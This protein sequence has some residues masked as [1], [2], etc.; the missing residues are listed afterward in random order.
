MVLEYFTSLKIIIELGQKQKKIAEN[1]E[2]LGAFRM[3]L[4]FWFKSSFSLK[5]N[6]IRNKKYAGENFEK[7]TYFIKML[8][9]TPFFRFPF[10]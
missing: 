5:Q 4:T 6:Y 3:K 8:N 9:F 10:I 7:R 2:K 1:F